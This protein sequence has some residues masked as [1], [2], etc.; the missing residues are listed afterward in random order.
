ML[1][2]HGAEH[3]GDHEG[4]QG[5]G[6]SNTDPEAPSHIDQLGIN[7]LGCDL[8]GFQRHPADG[9]V[10]RLCADDLRVHR[11]GVLGACCRSC[12]RCRLQGHATLR[13]APRPHLVHLGV[14]GAD[15]LDIRLRWKGCA[16]LRLQK[17]LWVSCEPFRARR[18]AEVIGLPFVFLVAD[19]ILRARSS[20][21][22]RDL[23]PTRILL[24]LSWEA[25]WHGRATQYVTLSRLLI[26]FTYCWGLPSNFRLQ[27]RPQK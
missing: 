6:K 21:R 26:Y 25:P 27:P 1:Q 2:R 24:L 19:G 9:T 18:I 5:D 4:E 8:A 7:L 10:A 11:A 3:P 14:H 15:V 17:R 22:T 13:A 23:G 20:C 12:Y 16:L